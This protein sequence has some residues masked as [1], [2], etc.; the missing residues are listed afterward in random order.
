MNQITR[1]PMTL[2]P[3]LYTLPGM[4]QA[5]VETGIEF[6]GGDG[7][8]LSMDLYRPSA[9]A[10]GP[11]PVVVLVPGYVDDGFLRMLGCRHKEMAS[12]ISWA[13]LIAASGMAAIAY[14][15]RVPAAD[16]AALL[17]HVTAQASALRLDGTRV[18]LWACSGHG[19]VALSAVL[20]DAPVKAAC[21]ALCYPYTMDLDGSTAVAD[22]AK[23]FRFTNACE[24]RSADEL[25]PDVPLFIARAGRDEMPGLNLA[26]DRLAA[27]ALAS[28]LPITLVNHPA[29]PHGFDLDDDGG[30]S[31]EVVRRT[32]AFLRFHLGVTPPREP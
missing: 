10:S 30:F 20:R 6:P 21:A 1:H 15:N 13:R 11:P 32:L 23:M 14:T 12:T 4:D 31:R 22:A 3:V 24:G 18:G 19:P 7:A 26:L 9:G 16:L 2:K 27:A 5:A 8:P 25:A 29:G 17:L 28:N